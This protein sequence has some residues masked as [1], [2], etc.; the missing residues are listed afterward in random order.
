MSL[1][2]YLRRDGARQK[3]VISLNID[4]LHILRKDPGYGAQAESLPWSPS[5]NEKTARLRTRFLFATLILHEFAHCAWQIRSLNKGEI[6]NPE[7]FLHDRPT[8]ELGHEF[9]NMIFSGLIRA[10]GSRDRPVSAPY[11]LRIGRY[12]GPGLAEL[13]SEEQGLYPRGQARDWG[14]VWRTEYP[15]H[16]KFCEKMFSKDFWDGEVARYGL[17]AC[18]PERIKGVRGFRMQIYNS[19]KQLNA[20]ET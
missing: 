15:V 3:T 16:M 12:P 11:G 2:S 20:L 13:E 18:R 1:I 19:L 4:H 10:S 5:T 7:P 8:N 14:R 17:A 9:E 6:A